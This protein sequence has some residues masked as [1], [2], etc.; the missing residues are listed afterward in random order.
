MHK[1]KKKPRRH[2]ATGYLGSLT[3]KE[4]C[5]LSSAAC[6]YQTLRKERY[7]RDRVTSRVWQRGKQTPS[8]MRHH[9]EGAK[10]FRFGNRCFRARGE[11]CGMRR[12]SSVF[13][14]SIRPHTLANTY[15]FHRPF[16]GGATLRDKVVTAII[17]R[18]AQD[19]QCT[20]CMEHSIGFEDGVVRCRSGV[21]DS[22]PIS[23]RNTSQN[24]CMHCKKAPR[25]ERGS[26]A[27]NVMSCVRMRY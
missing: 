24:G 7:K 9:L 17:H 26:A 11:G 1:K 16:H 4:N 23:N 19:T 10:H 12:T 8:N 3:Q 25:V 15:T 21:Y 2:L 6:C 20:S 18:H 14:C 13:T 27:K 22:E 5:V